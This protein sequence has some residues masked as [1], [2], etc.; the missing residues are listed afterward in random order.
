[1]AFVSSLNSSNHEDEEAVGTAK[2][3]VSAASVKTSTAGLTEETIYAFVSEQ[4][5]GSKIFNEDLLQIAE[6]DLEAMDLKWQL[7]LISIRAKKYYQRTG[8]KI[9]FNGRDVAG[10]DKS[11]VECFNCH[12]MGHF[13]RECRGPRQQ[14]NQ[15]QGFKNQQGTRRTVNVEE[16]SSKA[17]VAVDGAGFDWSFMEEEEEPANLG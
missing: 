6:D 7:A 10:Y 17:M 16:P 5:G 13:A 8:N 15:G 4:S 9:T 2:P 12:K 1:M 14:S 3:T 11:K